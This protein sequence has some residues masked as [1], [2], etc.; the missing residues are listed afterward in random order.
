MSDMS[1]ETENTT[2]TAAEQGDVMHHIQEM[3]GNLLQNAVGKMH[4]AD[5]GD[6]LGG[7]AEGT[8]DSNDPTAQMGIEE[9]KGFVDV[10][11]KFIDNIKVMIT[12]LETGS[13]E[14]GT[15]DKFLE[16]YMATADN[17][18]EIA[19]FSTKDPLTGLSN[20]YGFDNRLILEWNRATRDQSSLG[21]IIFGVSDYEGCDDKEKREELLKSISKRLESSIK[22]STDFIARWSE[23]EFAALLPI[24]EHG[25]ASIVTQRIR[26]EI[27]EMS[28]GGLPEKGGKPSI[29]IGV[30][31]HPPEPKEQPSDFINSAY[32]AF[33]KAKETAGDAIVFA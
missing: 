7:Q 25:G 29:S 21:L 10:M 27:G 9:I 26:N 2:P 1:K 13:M 3:I 33:K 24:T 4:K 15:D 16:G 20:R 23:D 8:D 30:C 5:M 28:I 6:K 11:Q 18:L 19:A 17:V 14:G 12:G 32:T 22:R 31:V